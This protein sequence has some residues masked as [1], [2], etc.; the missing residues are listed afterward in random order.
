MINEFRLQVIV[1]TRFK[2]RVTLSIEPFSSKSRL[3]NWAV[4]MFT[5]IAAKTI[6][7]LSSSPP[8]RSKM[9]EQ[10]IQQKLNR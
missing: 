3:K 2:K 10:T 7:K 4:S 1:S 5:P 8:W 6:A 9:S